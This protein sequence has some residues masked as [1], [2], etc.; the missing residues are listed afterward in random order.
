[1]N[2]F[3]IPDD[4]K[5]KSAFLNKFKFV[6]HQPPAARNW[7]TPKKHKKSSSDTK[8]SPSSSSSSSSTSSSSKGNSEVQC[9]RLAE[10]YHIYT[11]KE[12]LKSKKEVVYNVTLNMTDVAMGINSYYIIQLLELNEDQ[13]DDEETS[14][15]VIY[16]KWGRVGTDRGSDMKESF[17][18]LKKAKSKFEWAFEEKTGNKW[19]DKDTNFVKKPGKY[20]LVEIDYKTDVAALSNPSL[21]LSSIN[22]KL[23]KPLQELIGLIFDVKVME[24]TLADLNF[25]AEKTPLGMLS[26]AQI[27]KGFAILTKIQ[28]E[29]DSKDSNKTTLRDLSNQFYTVIPHNFGKSG[30]AVIKD[31]KLLTEKIEMLD[32]LSQIQI[33]YA[34]LSSSGASVAAGSLVDPLEVN[35]K[36]LNT[37]LEA[38]PHNSKEFKMVETFINNTATH[39]SSYSSYK[40]LEL[41]EVFEVEREGERERYEKL[42]RKEDIGNEM[43]LIHGSR[44]TNFV[45]ILSQGL[46]IAPPD[47]PA[48]GYL[49]GKGLYFA[50]MFA[51][52][53]NYC[54][55]TKTSETGLLL[56]AQVALG[57]IYETLSPKY[58][59]KPPT[60]YDS[61]QGVGE[62]YPDPAQSIKLPHKKKEVK[63]KEEDKSSSK[64]KKGK[65]KGKE[66]ESDED[67]DDD[68]NEEKDITVP[69][70]TPLKKK[71][72]GLKFNEFI[73]YN[74][75]QVYN[76]FLVK[77]KF[78]F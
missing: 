2:G 53:A 77:V 73:V 36:K 47:V 40:S 43:L 70:G 44:V 52:S 4:L 57:S 74:E 13:S 22:S 29:L 1:V 24:K 8:K 64:N 33:A 65:G 49:F 12:S 11:E 25:D 14:R 60:G 55:A 21:N 16:R 9:E 6:Q 48:S 54:R 20:F 51:K 15:Y 37:K 78:N 17:D 61:T 7:D 34:L 76:R 19:A 67:E 26:K 69:L 31:K 72:Q 18:D 5:E 46:K 32:T 63:V 10:T 30:G 58:M 59:D 66:A 3:K 41:L 39:P 71:A 28:N 27:D 50:D 23:P 56:L 35:Y 68:D 45:G 75:N 42:T 62:L 38:L